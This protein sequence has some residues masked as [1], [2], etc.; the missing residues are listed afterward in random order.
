MIGGLKPALIT[1]GIGLA[2][3]LAMVLLLAVEKNAHADTKQELADERSLVAD[4]RSQNATQAAER[5]EAAAAEVARMQ[6]QIDTAQQNEMQLRRD[7]SAVEAAREADR[8]NSETRIERLKREND[9][10]MAWAITVVPG[11]WID[12]MREPIDQAAAAA[13]TGDP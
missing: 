4:I 10:L 3:I 13:A 11:D 5:A 9:E 1:G 12:F 2:G 6:A 7:L 8:R